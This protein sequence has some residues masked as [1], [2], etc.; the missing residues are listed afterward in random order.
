MRKQLIQ[1]YVEPEQRKFLEEESKR[2]DKS[3]ALLIREALEKTYKIGGSKN[4]N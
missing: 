3:I 4:A 1:A 2:T